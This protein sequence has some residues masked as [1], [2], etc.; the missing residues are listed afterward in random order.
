M[1]KEM[2]E[3]EEMNTNP[4][5]RKE[6]KWAI[7]PMKQMRDNFLLPTIMFLG[8][9]GSGW[10]VY[11]LFSMNVSDFLFA[12]YLIAGSLVLCMI[13]RSITKD[14]RR[15]QDAVSKESRNGKNDDGNDT[16]RCDGEG[17]ERDRSEE[18]GDECLCGPEC[19][20]RENGTCCQGSKR[21]LKLV[22][23]SKAGELIL[24]SAGSAF[25]RL[26]SDAR[27]LADEIAR[28]ADEAAG[29]AS[30]ALFA[31]FGGKFGGSGFGGKLLLPGFGG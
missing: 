19:R 27:S 23:D 21:E 6:N 5:D 20:N 12:T 4:L 31:G 2:N 1:K 26:T 18:D 30:D 10:L 11:T 7:E 16:F 25:A 13:V 22:V 9:F 28:K 8:V 17:A 3:M 24:N 15:I 14:I 29:R